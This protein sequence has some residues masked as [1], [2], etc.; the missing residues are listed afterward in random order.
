M[1]VS[2][3]LVENDLIWQI[4]QKMN[5]MEEKEQQIRTGKKPN[6]GTAHGDEQRRFKKEF[7]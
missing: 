6:V 7:Q 4:C 2:C 3:L 5:K 1:M